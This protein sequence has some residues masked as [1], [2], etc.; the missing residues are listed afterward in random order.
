MQEAHCT[1]ARYDGMHGTLTCLNCCCRLE[2][3]HYKILQDTGYA[4]LLSLSTHVALSQVGAATLLWVQHWYAL[5]S[6][7]L[8]HAGPRMCTYLCQC[9]HCKR[10]RHLAFFYKLLQYFVQS[11][12]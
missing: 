11:Q 12:G 2:L 6:L 3:Q 9:R 1:S 10:F 5:G 7:S 8:P 4:W